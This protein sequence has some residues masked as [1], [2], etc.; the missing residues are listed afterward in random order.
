[1]GLIDFLRCVFG[2]RGHDYKN[3]RKKPGYLTCNR[4]GYRK[5]YR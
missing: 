2:D 4:C 1:M 5:K 3:S